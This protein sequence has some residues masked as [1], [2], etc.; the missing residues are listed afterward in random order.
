MRIRS[1]IISG[2]FF[3]LI[4]VF[5]GRITAPAQANVGSALQ[6][7]KGRSS[8]ETKKVDFQL[9]WDAW[10]LVEDRYVK[11]PPDEQKML[12]GAIDGMLGGLGDPYTAYMPADAAKQLEE[13]LK[14]SF[15]GIGAEIGFREEVLALIAPLPNSPAERAGLIPEDLI[16]E[17]DGTT[18]DELSLSEAVAKIRGKEGTMV[19]LGIFRKNWN[20]VRKI[21][22]KRERIDV[23]GTNLSF[24]ERDGKKLAILHILTF[25]NETAK[26]TSAQLT[27]IQKQGAQGIILDLRNNPGGLLTSAVDIAGLFLP[28]GTQVVTESFR[29]GKENR[30]QTKTAPETTLPMVVL[31]NGGSASAA[32]IL[33]GALK[34]QAMIPLIG[35]KTFG[36]G[37]V[38]EIESLKDGSSIR[39]TIAYWLTPK[40]THL[41]GEGITPDIEVGRSEE[42]RT[43]GRDP[44]RDKA[45]EVLMG[46]LPATK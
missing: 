23:Q 35:E 38:Q 18:T 24:V 26:E 9:F 34:D 19:T 14:G 27:E 29:N 33:A 43:A 30:L 20:E 40:G 16:V 10:K 17:I 32:E 41:E 25:D 45:V 12:E 4:G 46:R 5:L 22:I 1:V 3:L 36:K 11:Q 2:I 28:R 13:D 6:V 21:E 44:Q 8:S 31:A 39:L 42:D 15:E 7:L 37:S